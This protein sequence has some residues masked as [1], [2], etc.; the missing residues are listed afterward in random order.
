MEKD[1]PHKLIFKQSNTLNNI[2]V[3]QLG[4]M[5]YLK[6]N[7]SVQ[8]VRCTSGSACWHKYNKEMSAML[9]HLKPQSH[10]LEAG[11][12][13]GALANNILKNH[14]V[15]LLTT[16]EIDPAVISLYESIFKEFND[17][18][19]FENSH[20]VV[21]ADLREFLTTNKKNTMRCLLTVFYRRMHLLLSPLI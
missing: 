17:C 7:E 8:G 12:G 5:T 3:H 2:E 4:S 13:T 9:A 14:N 15:S 19:R 21:N 10:V 6:F 18:D 11:L 16:V 1:S 20:S